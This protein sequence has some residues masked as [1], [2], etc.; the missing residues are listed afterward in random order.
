MPMIN[1][2]D[3]NDFRTYLADWYDA[4]KKDNPNF[5]FQ[6]IA[7][8][9]G[10]KNKGFIYNI[11]KGDKLLSKSNILKI[12]KA[13]GHNRYEADY[14][15][16]LVAFNQTEDPTERK[17]FFEKLNR[18]TN[19]GKPISPAQVLRKDQYKFYSNWHHA[20]IRSIIDMY[21]FRDDYKWLAKMVNP[22]V[23]VAQAKQSV[24]LL[25]KL[26]LICKGDDGIY[27]ISDKCLTTGK[28][29]IHVA[30][31]N[32]NLA[33][34]DLAKRAFTEFPLKVRNMSGLTLGVSECG[35]GKICEEIAHFQKKIMEI[36][37]TDEEADRVY[38]LN[39][40]FFPTSNNDQQSR[41][42]RTV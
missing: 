26:E 5:S 7:N 20:M 38:Q 30:F 12:S 16:N 31:Q 28:D 41:K 19:M 39:F 23:S 18:I 35:Y 42:R 34:T 15:E 8:K 27:R 4:K 36:A 21:E 10:I 14:F 1:V 11:I 17:Y 33:C 2:F 9:A 22:P 32:F 3:Y 13:L 6:L 37:N 24:R 29:F 40:H 25:K